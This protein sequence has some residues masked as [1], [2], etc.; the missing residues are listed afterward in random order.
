MWR[1][2]TQVGED[3]AALCAAY[4]ALGVG[5]RDPVAIF[6]SNSEHWAITDLAAQRR[7]AVLVPLYHTYGVRA[8]AFILRQ[9]QTRVVVCAHE[10]FA[11]LLDC[12]QSCIQK[13]EEKKSLETTTTTTTTTTSEQE[14]QE[15]QKP[16]AKKQEQ[17]GFNEDDCDEEDEEEGKDDECVVSTIILIP[18]MA[19]PH[20][21]E[22]VEESLLKRAKEYGIRVVSWAEAL[23]MGRASPVEAT[24]TGSEDLD[25]IVYTSGTSGLPKGVMIPHRALV[26]TVDNVCGHYDLGLPASANVHLSYLPLA[27]VYERCFLHVM[28]RV[29][30]AVGFFSGSAA[31][32]VADMRALRPTFLIGVPRVWKRVHDRVEA[33]VAAA[34]FYQRWLFRWACASKKAAQEAGTSTW[35]DWDGLVLRTVREQ[36]GGR[37]RWLG[38]AS[39]P[40]PPELAGWL[41]RV[42]GAHVVLMYGLTETVGGVTASQYAHPTQRLRADPRSS[43]HVCRHAA[44]RLVDAPE[45]GYRVAHTPPA[46][47]VL[48]RGASVAAGYYRRPRRTAAAWDAGGW[49]RTGDIGVANADGSLTIVDRRKNIFKLAQGEYVPAE[50]LEALFAHSPRVAQAMVHGVSTEACV[51]ALVV[52][53]FSVLA[54]DPAL[55]EGARALAA[56]AAEGDAASAAQ[57]CARPELCDLLQR[58]L[59]GLAADA[60][61][62]HFQVPR[63]VVAVP[64]PWSVENDLT[65]PTMKLKRPNIVAHYKDV[66]ADA[67]REAALELENKSPSSSG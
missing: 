64:G 32:L 61:L 60:A 55:S 15:E 37:A 57:L 31:R 58:T 10:S 14:K 46:G 24:P 18:P 42:L 47:E 56:A 45:L 44:V 26:A 22:P 53:A 54:A 11:A 52:P 12:I 41:A 19:G 25:A 36:L 13:D 27:H 39:A 50:H 40:L 65:T 6:A 29:G 33:S 63:R 59:A 9:V 3:V 43:G 23:E 48:V 49:F 1:T 66:L 67:I 30:G 28:L 8:L 51:V 2:W 21:D 62:P 7:G 34:P 20:E 35:L 38:S 4:A 17:E 5:Q 16:K